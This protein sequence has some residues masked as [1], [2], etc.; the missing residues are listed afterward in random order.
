MKCR[1]TFGFLVLMA[2]LISNASYSQ[3]LL[4]RAASKAKQKLEEKAEKK[5]EEKIDEAIEKQAEQNNTEDSE[6]QNSGAENPGQRDQRRMQGILKGIG[7]SGEP[8]PI[9]ESYNFTAKIHMHMENRDAKNKITSQGEFISYMNPGQVNFAYE[10]LSGDMDNKG[11][12]VFIIDIKN[13]ATLIL[14]EEAGAKK[15]IVY[16]LDFRPEEN[17]IPEGS[18]KAETDIRNI[19]SINPQI[20]KTG[21]TKQIAGYPC[22]EYVYVDPEND[23]EI[24]YWLTDNLSI[25]TNNYLGSALKSYLWTAGSASGFL[26]ESEML[27]KETG[28]KSF[29]QVTEVDTNVGI[30]FLTSDYQITNLGNMTMP[31]GK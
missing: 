12:G 31:A 10:I 3:S 28:E 16:G 9:E 5:V 27:D 4:E 15:G 20:K 14:T 29:M 21:R 30:K 8:V 19:E 18:G 2:V 22:E 6:G 1:T 23:G 24:R 17:V 7:L 26:M 13:K 11:K 25:K